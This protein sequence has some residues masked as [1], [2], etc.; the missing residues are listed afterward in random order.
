MTALPEYRALHQINTRVWLTEFAA[1]DIPGSGFA[2]TGHTPSIAISVAIK[3]WRACGNGFRSVA[4]G[5]C[6]IL[7]GVT[8]RRIIRGSR[9][10]R[11]SHPQR[12]PDLPFS[13][14]EVAGVSPYFVEQMKPN[15]NE[16][17][18]Q[19]F[20][21]TFTNQTQA[22]Q[23]QDAIIKCGDESLIE[24]ADSLVVTCDAAGKV[25]VYKSADLVYGSASAGTV[26]GFIVGLIFLQPWVGSVVGLGAGAV[27]G[28]LSDLGI[29]AEFVRK[30]GATLTPGTSALFMLGRN[31]QLDKL[32]EQIAPLFTGCTILQSTV[33]KAREDEVRRMLGGT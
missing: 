9:I 4:C 18:N 6:S 12:E 14:I 15:S 7:C 10:S 26:V 31:G 3:R 20:V 33:T 29:D 30:V 27:L 11:V 24:L 19:V 28:A 13:L 8:G 17:K 23:L 21:L 32:R 5:G 16:V 22:F 1:G 2:I 25:K